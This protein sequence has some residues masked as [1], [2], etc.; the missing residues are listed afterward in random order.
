MDKLYVTKQIFKF[1]AYLYNF[2][3]IEF[4]VNFHLGDGKIFAESTSNAIAID[5]VDE[6]QFK[7]YTQN[8]ELGIVF[9]IINVYTNSFF[10]DLKLTSIITSFDINNGTKQFPKNKYPM[11]VDVYF[12]H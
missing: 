8:D 12:P 7:I 4:D 2:D 3:G 1:F 9:D 11:I 5:F 6:Y 10:D